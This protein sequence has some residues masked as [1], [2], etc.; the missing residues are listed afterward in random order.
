MSYCSL[1]WLAYYAFRIGEKFRDGLGLGAWMAFVI[2]NGIQ[3]LS[4]YGG[5]LAALIWVRAVRVR[6]SADRARV[7]VHTVAAVGVFLGLC[8]W[9]LVPVVLVLLDVKREQV[10]HWDESLFSVVQCLLNRPLPNWSEVIPGR[11][12]AAFIELNTYVGAVVVA[13]ALLSLTHGWRWWHTLA[14]VCG[15]LAVGSTE[16]YHPS[17]W[18]ETW[19]FFSSAHVV[20]RW[21]FVALLGV[22]LAAGSVLARWRRSPNLLASVAAA[23]LAVVIAVDFISLAHQQFPLAFSVAPE[24]RFF[25]GPA[26]PDIVNVRQGLGYPC[27]M[28]GYG[29]IEGYEPMLGYRRDAPT[30][31]RA[32]EDPD[33][34]GE[35]WTAEGRIEPVF[36]SPNRLVFQV[37]PGQEVFINQNPSAWWWANGRPAFAG[38][39]C[40]EPMVPFAVT[41]DRTGRLELRIHPRGL[42]IGIG[43]HVLGCA[44]LAAAWLARPRRIE[45]SDVMGPRGY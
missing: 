14:L 39:R 3:Y 25:P 42:F 11:H 4:F 34:R 15:W 23:L 32:R 33:Y 37:A 1:P 24:P 40:A 13:L 27:V 10:T 6:P 35:S 30:L 18:L 44:L 7:L 19:P 26:V 5:L 38:R 29:V 45:Q 2:L 9:R 31:R 20:T 16:W 28:R 17:Y 21:R 12:W 36:W 43:L 8:S 41:A 22:G